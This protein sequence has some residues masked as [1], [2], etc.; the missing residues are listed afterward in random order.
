MPFDDVPVNAFFYAP[1]FWA[2]DHNVTN[3]T[4]AN[5]F[6]PY[7]A[8]QRAQVVTFLWRAAGHPEPVST[9]NPFV[10]VKEDDY[11][12]K[13]V[14]WAL[15]NGITNGMD[16]T[17]F[18]PF[19]VCNR[20]QVVTFLYRSMGEPAVYGVSHVFTDVDPDGFYYGAMLWAVEERITLGLTS[21][22]FGPNVDCNRAQI[23]T[24][25]HRASY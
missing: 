17:H 1:V 6:S 23:V 11:Y 20:A 15:E 22:T 16:S 3:G 5:S 24:F 13:A 10:D 25:L 9:E 2:I 8:C 19:E 12:Y 4:S 14:L 18:G 7:A 21:N